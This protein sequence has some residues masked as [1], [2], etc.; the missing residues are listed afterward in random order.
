MSS[1]LLEPQ[2]LKMMGSATLFAADLVGADVTYHPFRL[3]N[4]Y[5]IYH[6]HA[7][8]ENWITVMETKVV[9]VA[10]P[11]WSAN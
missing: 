11:S 5:L 8:E 2:L 6:Y 1:F 9:A 4:C 10:S 7:M 3:S